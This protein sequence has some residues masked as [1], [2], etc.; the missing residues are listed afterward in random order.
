MLSL[1]SLAFLNPWVL[2]ALAALPILWWLLRAI[3]PS[4][5]TQVF[6]GVR[7]LLG[8]DDEERQ[9]HTTPWWLLL[10]RCLAVAAALIGFAQPVLNLNA[11]IAGGSGTLL[12]L[13]DQ[14]W[15]SAPEWAERTAAARALLDEADDA[16]RDVILWRAAEGGAPLVVSAKVAQA[17]LGSTVPRPWSPDPAAVLAAVQER[18]DEIGDIGEVVWLH[19]GLAREG[20]E[21][22][23]AYLSDA[24]SLRLIGPAAAAHAVTPPRIED[25]GLAV[26][27]LRAGGGVEAVS[28]IAMAEAEGG[29]ERRIAV[30]RAEFNAEEQRATVQF[31]LPPELQNT[32]TRVVLLDRPSAGGAAFADGSIRRITAGL[33]ATEADTAVTT[34]VSPTHYI[35]KALVPWADMARGDI[36][37]V[38]DMDSSAI[39]L[40]DHGEMADEERDRLTEWVENGGL[41]IRFAGPRLAASIGASGLRSAAVGDDPLLPVRLRRGGRVLGGALAWSTPRALGPFAQQ[42]PFRGLALPDEVDVR[43]QVLAEPSPDLQGKVWASLDDGTPLVT[44]KRLGEGRVV[45]FHVSSD[46]EWSSLPL[47]GL[48]VEMLGRLVT[49]APGHTASEPDPAELADTIWR[50][51]LFMGADGQPQQVS[52]LSQSVAGEA[53]VSAQTGPDLPPGIYARADGSASG[54]ES[55]RSVVINLTKE[56]A[57]LSPFPPPPAGAVVETL[58]GDAPV[59]YGPWLLAIALVLA[60]VDVLGT[61]FV[62][63]RLGSRTAQTAA[64]ALIAVA[65]AAAPDAHAQ[66]DEDVSPE[67]VPATAETTLGYVLTGNERLDNISRRGLVG[68]GNALARRT[69]IE[70]G[71]PVGVDPGTNEAAFYPV[72]YWPL[73]AETLPSSTQLQGLADYIRGGGLLIIDTQN[74]SSGFSGASAVQMRE[75]A[76]ALNLPPLAPVDQDHVLTRAFYLLS[77]FPGRWRGARVW[78]EAPPLREDGTPEAADIPQFDRIDDNVSPVLVGS[79]DWAAAWAIDD[80]GY[81]MFPIGRPGDR[82]REMAIRFGVNAVMYALTGNYKSDQVHAPAVLERLGQ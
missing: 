2:A 60:A 73:T 6:A 47:S 41:L 77:A 43:T 70:P 59:R 34:L 48:F 27:V 56:D 25:G 51:D 7:L 16:G 58:G 33:V 69:A 32:V 11:R 36:G 12:I 72:M 78:A 18:A 13:M 55:A 15:A 1:G 9:T 38:L 82:Q 40:V 42:S 50:A 49:L 44:A 64:A 30:E 68:L 71:P 81:P 66:S 5:R 10:L 54:N 65:L 4:P 23:L 39:V 17:T 19:D 14:G 21:D 26:D 28:V 3:P 46:A 22:L 57:V 8:L 45:L 29:G 63:G 76:R 31:N 79:A 74:G 24:G 35:E 62:S 80:R 67:A 20:T 52:S 75:I 53:L 37:S 61:L